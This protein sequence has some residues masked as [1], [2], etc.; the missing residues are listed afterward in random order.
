[1]LSLLSNQ[2]PVGVGKNFCGAGW[3]PG[4]GGK[5]G[6]F[7]PVPGG[8]LLPWQIVGRGKPVR[9][10]R[11]RPAFPVQAARPKSR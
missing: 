4:I 9:K 5:H 3:A 6:D 1:M 11:G 2:G 10:R 7:G 8:P